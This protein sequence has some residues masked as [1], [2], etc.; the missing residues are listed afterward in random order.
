MSDPENKKLKKFCEDPLGI[1][2]PCTS[3]S[4]EKSFPDDKFSEVDQ[5]GFLTINSF[6]SDKHSSEKHHIEKSISIT[7][8][9]ESGLPTKEDYARFYFSEKLDVLDCE[10]IAKLAE[11]YK[12]RFETLCVD[13]AQKMKSLIINEYGKIRGLKTVP[14]RSIFSFDFGTKIRKV[15]K[16][17]NITISRNTLNRVKN[18]ID[19]YKSTQK[20]LVD[21]HEESYNKIFTF[22]NEHLEFSEYIESKKTGKFKISDIKISS[23]TGELELRSWLIENLR[24]AFPN[25]LEIPLDNNLLSWFLFG[26]SPSYAEQ[27]FVNFKLITSEVYKRFEFRDLLGIDYRVSKLTIRDFEKKGIEINQSNLNSLQQKVTYLIYEYVLYKEHDKPY[28][29]DTTEYGIEVGR[30]YWTPEYFVIRVVFF[31]TTESNNGEIKDFK[32]IGD[33]SGIEKI[34]RNLRQGYGFGKTYLDLLRYVEDL[35]NNRPTNSD[36][37]VFNDALKTLEV[38]DEI[39]FLRS[40]ARGIELGEYDSDFERI[41]HHYLISEIS[42]L[43]VH[44]VPIV[45]AIGKREIV[46]KDENGNDV[47]KRIHY[48]FHYDCYLKL[49][50][51]LRECFGLDKRWRAI[52]V[53]A[54]GSYWH[55][56]DYPIHIERD[57]FKRAISE[58]EDIIEIEIW[59]NIDQNLW[60]SEFIRQI[61]EQAGTEIN[62]DDLLK[63]KKNFNDFKNY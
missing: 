52:G 5:K 12:I 62:E 8:L 57:K 39:Y 26:D 58:Q 17:E 49:T 27:S 34:Q 45:E 3:N 22:I 1:R 63:V 41:V 46:L 55:G 20:T 19:K 4:I 32:T 48:A 14:L 25:K 2:N 43:F 31:S 53:E 59:D 23:S 7:K 50:N 54:Q 37:E 10:K 21:A 60:I 44:D 38:Y 28:A 61:N 16:R 29:S 13:K 11:E 51:E 36:I 30:V 24:Y 35:Y 42:P 18:E 6:M 47:T 56:Q 33:D 9:F 15:I 40:K